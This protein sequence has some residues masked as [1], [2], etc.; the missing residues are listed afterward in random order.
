[1]KFETLVRA[2][3]ENEKNLSGVFAHAPMARRVAESW[4]RIALR[5]ILVVAIACFFTLTAKAATFTVTNTND[6]GA[7]SL[8]QAILD[9]NANLGA[10]QISFNIPGVGVHTIAPMTPLPVITDPVVIDGYTQPGASANTQTSGDNALLLIELTGINAAAGTAGLS[11]SGGGSTIKGLVVNRF[12]KVDAQTSD[13]AIQLTGKGGNTIAGNFIGTDPTGII[14]SNNYYGIIVDDCPSNT[15]GGTAPA[16]RNLISGS[17]YR[18]LSIIH[19]KALNNVVQGNFVGIDATGANELRNQYGVAVDTMGAAVG[20]TVIG[21]TTAGAGNV[22]SGNSNCI[23]LREN[24][25]LIQGNLIGTD[26]TGKIALGNNIG[27]N[28]STV[29]NVTIGG[30]TPAARNVI[31]GNFEAGIETSIF[32]SGIVIQGNYIGADIN[33]NPS[34][35]NGIGVFSVASNFTIGGTT[36]GAGNVIAG[37]SAQGVAIGGLVTAADTVVGNSIFNNG[38]LG[39]DIGLDGV[40]SN[41]PGDGD[42]GA[43]LLQNYPVLASAVL[44]AGT[45]TVNATLNSAANKQFRVEFFSNN[46]CDPSTFGQGQ[47]FIGSANVTTNGSGD[48]GF[49]QMFSG[50][51]AGQFITT[52]ATDPAGNTSEFSQCRQITPAGSSVSLQFSAANYTVA[53]KGGTATISVTRTGGNLGAVSVNY[54][55]LNGTATAGSDY[56]AASGTLNWADG[57]ASL[58]TFAVTIKDDALNEVNETVNL[59]LTNPTGGA[60]LGGLSSATLSITDDDPMPGLSISDVSKAEGDNGTTDFIF[61]VTLSAASGQNVFVDYVTADGSAHANSDFVF[62]S[63]NLGI[64]AGTMSRDI[65]VRVFGDTQFEPNEAFFLNLSNPVGAVLTKAQGTGTIVNDDAPK[66]S[67]DDVSQAEGNNGTTNFTFTISLAGPSGQQVSVNYTTADNTAQAG[68]DYQ[69]ANDIVTFAPG[70]TS[71]QVTVLVNGDSQVESNETFV[72]NL[73]NLNNAAVGKVTGVGTIVNDDNSSSPTIQFSQATYAVQEDLGAITVTVTRSGDTSGAA[74]VDYATTDGTAAQKTDF[75]YAAGTLTFAPGETS[76]TITVLVN[77]DTYNESGETFGVTLKNPSGAAIGAQGVALVTITDDVPESIG[78]PIDD[79][80]SFVYM[81]YHDFLNREPD[82]AGLAFWTNQITSCNGDATCIAAA[83]V[84]VSAS[85]F[86]SIEFQETAYVLYLIQK[87]SYS[88]MPRYASFM[89]DLQEVSRGLV[90]K[91][92]GWQQKLSDNQAQFADKWINR[93]E[94]KAVY[95]GLSNDAYVTALYKNAGIVPP[96]A[97]KDKLVAALDTASM[98]RSTVLLEVANDTTFR[99]QEQRAAFVLMEYFGYLRRDPD[100]T[101]D[102]DLSGYNFWLNKLN[103]FGGDYIEAEMIKAFIVSSE[104]RQRFGN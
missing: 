4:K 71:K 56:V 58:K 21:G 45:T 54:T 51:S 49:A 26:S 32:T 47:T 53:E 33:G 90:V 17:I 8:R 92:P 57:D 83:R 74:A 77:E 7:G 70:E 93:P 43:N 44:N 1:M 25:V 9:A 16:A 18:G 97:E 85:F 66:V 86:R 10:D 30:T 39:I 40:T 13:I 61:T 23:Q 34:V 102:S 38:S 20:N 35:G 99:Q 95:D 37:N 73:Y 15:I 42:G 11:I 94:F 88:N 28:L 3:F 52:T 91:A 101:P 82:P 29:N 46:S 19:A 62:L 79:A 41:D 96:Q 48:A 55:T 75:E 100:A 64:G 84:N 6:S 2:T 12:D 103:Q 36:A 78:N 68:S 72:V 22:I 50:L 98:N 104:Y 89:S 87:E 76:K 27:I 24:G 59:T 60:V 67:I 5:G 65:T 80:Q 31:S 69:A 81:H 63:G 14:K